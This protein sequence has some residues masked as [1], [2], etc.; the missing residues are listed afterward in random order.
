MGAEARG[1]LR[2]VTDTIFARAYGLDKTLGTDEAWEMAPLN[3]MGQYQKTI[4]PVLR[5]QGD[6]RGLELGWDRLISLEIAMME[7]VE[8]E[9][10]EAEFGSRRLP[11][12]WWAK[13]MDVAETGG[14]G[15]AAT[16]MLRHLENN[17]D[18]DQAEAWIIDLTHVVN[19][20]DL[21]GEDFEKD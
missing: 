12:L 16:G 13:W 11:S 8:D 17:L 9:K 18:H 10:S 2:S 14:R 3:V 6:T 1:L 7:P 20:G 4:F 21:E 15:K 19:G 5:E